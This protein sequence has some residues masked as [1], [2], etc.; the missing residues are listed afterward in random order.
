MASSNSGSYT[1]FLKR[2]KCVV[3]A[4]Q[5]ARNKYRDNNISKKPRSKNVVYNLLHNGSRVA[6][7]KR[8]FFVI[9]VITNK[10]CERLSNVL[11][12]QC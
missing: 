6:A 5:Y 2:R 7:C 1:P 8:A 11:H 12:N 10:R 9:F 4:D 3:N